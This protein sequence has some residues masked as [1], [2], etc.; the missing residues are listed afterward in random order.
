MLQVLKSRSHRRARRANFRSPRLHKV[1]SDS[2]DMQWCPQCTSGKG[3]TR[4]PTPTGSLDCC[5]QPRNSRSK[6]IY[7][8]GIPFTVSCETGNLPLS[9]E[10]FGVDSPHPRCRG[11]ALPNRSLSRNTLIGTLKGGVL[12]GTLSASAPACRQ[13]GAQKQNPKEMPATGSGTPIKMNT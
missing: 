2:A 10:Y 3:R 1:D 6:T 12:L 8:F 13:A 4:P 5:Q 11:S 9:A 7:M